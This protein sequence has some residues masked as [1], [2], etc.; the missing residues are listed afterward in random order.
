MRAC[1]QLLHELLPYPIFEDADRTL[2]HS[3]FKFGASYGGISCGSRVW[4][5]RG[6]RL[7]ETD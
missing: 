7:V 3:V 5:N 6:T 2:I 4:Q 1:L